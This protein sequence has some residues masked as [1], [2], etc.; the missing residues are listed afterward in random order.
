MT[1]L[2]DKAFQGSAL[3]LVMS[4]LQSKNASKTELDAIRKLLDEQGGKP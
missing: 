2:L 4:A 3:K 1:D